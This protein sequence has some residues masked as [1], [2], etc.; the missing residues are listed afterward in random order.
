MRGCV[1]CALVILSALDN[2][3]GSL[4]SPHR[5]KVWGNGAP[6][7]QEGLYCSG[8]SDIA[9]RSVPSIPSPAGL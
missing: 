4:W 8:S 5:N 6:L 1:A 2:D 9:G 3:L 7:M